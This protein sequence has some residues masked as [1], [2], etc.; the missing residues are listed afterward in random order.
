MLFI[1]GI[2]GNAETD[3]V[4]TVKATVNTVTATENRE[5]RGGPSREQ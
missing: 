1:L 2:K 4:G 3:F 5:E